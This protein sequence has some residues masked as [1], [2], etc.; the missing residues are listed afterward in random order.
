MLLIAGAPSEFCVEWAIAA[1]DVV[2]E[3]H[4]SALVAHVK[5]VADT[6]A[7]PDLYAQWRWLLIDHAVFSATEFLVQKNRFLTVPQW[8][9]WLEE[10]YEPIPPTQAPGGVIAVCGSC[11][12]WMAPDSGGAWCCSTTRCRSLQNLAPSTFVEAEKAVRLRSELVRFIALPG[13]PE[14]DLALALAA[15]GA[16]VI[17]FPGLD[18]LDLLAA[19]PDGYSV[20]I[21]VKDWVKPYLLARRIKMFPDWQPG[22]HPFGYQRGCL[23]VPKDRVAANPRYCTIVRQNSAALK[24]QPYIEVLSD[25]ALIASC[26]DT[27]VAGEVVC[28]P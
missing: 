20:G 17:L 23:V 9:T 10:S 7:R 18:A 1:Y 19:W 26:P 13:R 8:A 2:S 11:Q 16:R 24:A 3:I 15:R 27:G 21:D 22:V 4:E 6:L 25:E 12:Q 14:I 5:N 28:G